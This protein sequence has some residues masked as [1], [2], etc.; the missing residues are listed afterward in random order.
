MQRHDPQDGSFY[1][2]IDRFPV[3]NK[4]VVF[5]RNSMMKPASISSVLSPTIK[6]LRPSPAIAASG[7]SNLFWCADRPD[8]TVA[9]IICNSWRGCDIYTAH[10]FMFFSQYKLLEALQSNGL[11]K[12]E[13]VLAD[14]LLFSLLLDHFLTFF[15]SLFVHKVLNLVVIRY[16]KL[17][18]RLM[19]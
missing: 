7:F 2:S 19:V 13:E 17:N 6:Y 11:N 8:F 14:V 18:V 1:S 16:L 5:T 4:V 9:L 12:W 15:H 3:Y 10:G